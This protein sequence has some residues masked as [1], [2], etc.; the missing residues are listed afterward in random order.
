MDTIIEPFRIKS[1]EPIRLTTRPERARLLAEARHNLFNLRSE[2]V[3]IDLPTDSG[4]SAMSAAQWG[5]LM[6]GDESYAGSSSYHRFE[7]A[8]RRVMPF[9]HVIP[10]HQGRAAERILFEIAG[11][12]GQVVP[13][14]THF[15]TTRADVE[16]SGA[17]AVDLVIEEGHAPQSRH[18]FKGNIDTERLRA[19]LEKESER[20]PLVMLTL[21]NNSGGGQPV[22]LE[23]VRAAKAICGMYGLPLFI[24][25]CRFAENAFLIKRREE[26]QHDRPVEEIAR[27]I[28]SEADGATMSAK[29]DGPA[30]IG[31]W[32][33]MNDDAW[34]EEAR[35]LLILTGGFPP[36]AAWRGAI[37][38][39]SRRGSRRSCARTTCATA[40]NPLPTW[41]GR[42]GRGACPSWSRRAATPSTW[43][44]GRSSRTSRRFSTRG[45]RWRARSTL[46]GA[47]AAARSARS[48]SV[49]GP[50]APKRPRAWSWCAWRSRAASTPRATS[51]T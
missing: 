40:S 14:N 39:P 34:G 9:E 26:G 20:V 37:W 31:G 6:R 32:L 47:F 25:A 28:F 16:A 15:D 43:T 45:R 4:T 42:C 48:C 23:N 13:S 5:A 2:D 51:T 30:N 17:E 49:A 22:S 35:N 50:T 21:T 33:A 44:R 29:R 8:V 7:E 19:L 24:D 18:P 46:K 11:G 1:V 10:T 3:I 36:T 12:E 38:R 41:A 27:A